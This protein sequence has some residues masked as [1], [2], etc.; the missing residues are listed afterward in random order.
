MACILKTPP[1]STAVNVCEPR[2]RAQQSFPGF[3]WDLALSLWRAAI[4]PR[5]CN[6]SDGYAGSTANVIAMLTPGA[7]PRQPCRE[8]GPPTWYQAIVPTC[9]LLLSRGNVNYYPSIQIYP[10]VDLKAMYWFK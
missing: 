10:L 8:R 2:M 7:T 4:C 9:D 6:T 5:V 3:S 1:V